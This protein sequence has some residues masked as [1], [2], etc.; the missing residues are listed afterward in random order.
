MARTQYRDKN[1]VYLL[2][3]EK[4]LHHFEK[5][6]KTSYGKELRDGLCSDGLSKPEVCRKW[7]ICVRTYNSWIE[8]YP[9]F[10]YSDEVAKRD[11]AC[12]WFEVLRSAATGQMKGSD[13]L[14]SQALKN[15]DEIHWVDTAAPTKDKDDEVR[16]ITINVLPPREE[17]KLI[18]DITGNIVSIGTTIDADRS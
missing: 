6:Y 11:R 7:G 4:Q 15:I 5:K 3:Y 2:P 1:G 16:T 13:R 12:W 17:P 14:I 9:D 18:S 8:K 10:K